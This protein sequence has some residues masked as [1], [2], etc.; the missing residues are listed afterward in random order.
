VKHIRH[1]QVAGIE[2]F[3]CDFAVCID[4]AERLTNGIV[5]DHVC[6][7]ILPR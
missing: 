4:T 6:A 3:P 1:G 5:W 2:S 7:F